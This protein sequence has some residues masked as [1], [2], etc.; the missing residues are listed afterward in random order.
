[1]YTYIV[2]AVFLA[3][4]PPDIRPYTVYIYYIWF[5]PTLCRACVC[6]SEFVHVGGEVNG[7]VFGSVHA[8]DRL[9]VCV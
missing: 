4:K 9:S 1:M 8:G 2:Y 7:E 5:W 6:L 3:G